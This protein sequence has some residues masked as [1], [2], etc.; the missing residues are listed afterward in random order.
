[1]KTG[2]KAAQ[3]Q[4]GCSS[5]WREILKRFSAQIAVSLVAVITLDELIN[6][7]ERWLTLGWLG[8]IITHDRH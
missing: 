7:Q 8:F 6:Y 5:E 1:M 2:S 3:F 4:T